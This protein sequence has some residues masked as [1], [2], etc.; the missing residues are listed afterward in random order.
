MSASFHSYKKHAFTPTIGGAGMSFRKSRPGSRVKASGGQIKSI[1][2]GQVIT[3]QRLITMAGNVP[4]NER[5]RRAISSR[6]SGALLAPPSSD[7]RVFATNKGEIGICLMQP[8]SS[9]RQS[10]SNDTDVTFISG[11]N[12]LDRSTPVF[13]PVVFQTRSDPSDPSSPANATCAI[14]GCQTIINT[15]CQN[16]NNGD[17]IYW[18]MNPWMIKDEDGNL[19]PGVRAPEGLPSE[20]MY[21]QTR[22][23]NAS[24]L[25]SFH[26]SLEAGMQRMFQHKEFA[27]KL[28]KITDDE[29]LHLELVKLCDEVCTKERNIAE[30]MPVRAW[31]LLTANFRLHNQLKISGYLG[32]ISG[33]ERLRVFLMT[34]RA[35]L[36]AL[37]EDE[38]RS[39]E[40]LR[41]YERSLPHAQDVPSRH[42]DKDA[43]VNSKALHDLLHPSPEH[44]NKATYNPQQELLDAEGRIL[45]LCN[46]RIQLALQ[47]QSHYFSRF[48]A[49]VALSSAPPGHPFD[50][51]LGRI[52]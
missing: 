44:M 9:F 38:E 28:R 5:E 39:E 30:D 7:N 19:I 17:S 35:M 4:R 45:M 24:S 26:Q 47:R 11:V 29:K 15:G 2:R 32:A 8:G 25:W 51:L 12:G 37:Q 6:G 21:I 40:V 22:P 18:D 14:E 34:L 27:T 13:M 42:P 46:S 31:L 43:S 33:E 52:Q 3:P 23:F 10:L 50:I 1:G 16:I 49:G 41:D 20:K 36:R 48:A